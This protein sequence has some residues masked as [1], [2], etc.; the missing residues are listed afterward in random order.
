[1]LT[2]RARALDPEQ[3]ATLRARIATDGVH[4]LARRFGVSREALL[5]AAIGADVRR[6]TLFVIEHGI[7]P[8][9]VGRYDA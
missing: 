9:T 2:T 3:Q 5:R 1:M 7:L 8:G 6:S 4:A